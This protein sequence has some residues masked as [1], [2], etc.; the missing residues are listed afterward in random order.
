MEEIAEGTPERAEFEAGFRS[1]MSDSLGVEEEAIRKRIS[2][3]LS[4][5]ER[6]A[7]ADI[8]I[9]NSGDEVSLRAQLDEKW[10][11]IK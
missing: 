6:R 7:K 3:Q 10:D 11:R 1:A 5:D 9:D 8:I 2:S 4:N